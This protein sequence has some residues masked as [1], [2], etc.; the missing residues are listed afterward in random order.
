MNIKRIWTL[1]IGSVVGLFL[2]VACGASATSTLVPTPAP[3]PAPAATPAPGSGLT[4]VATPSPVASSDG[5]GTAPTQAVDNPAPSSGPVPTAVLSPVAAPDSSSEA[6]PAAD[7]GVVPDP[8]FQA[9][10]N[11]SRLSTAVWETDF[12][13]HTVAFDEILSGGPG[14]DGIPPIDDPKFTTP[15]LANEWLG[16]LEPV[17]AFEHNGDTRAY[18]LQ[19][20]MWH[21]VVNDVVG[22][23]PVL[24]TFCPLCNSAV[25]FKRT[26]D[27]V[28]LDFGVS[29]N[30]RNSDLIMWDRQ[31]ET[32][33]QQLL[34]VGIVG[35]LAGRRLTFLPAP[36]VSWSDFRDAHPDGK[37]LS[38]D[39]GLSRRYGQNPYV[40]YDRVDNPPFLFRGDPDGRVQ[41]KER[42][43][44]FTIGSVDVAFPFSVLEDEKVVNYNVNGRDV[45]VFFKPGTRTALGGASIGDAA[46]IGATGVFDAVLDGWKLTFRPDGDAYVDNGTGSTWS[47]LGTATEGPLAGSNLVPITHANHFWFAWGAFKPDTMIYQGAG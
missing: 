31:T 40:G 24:V 15:E 46:E 34:G 22:G 47:I 5:A 16:D 42:V 12:S 19:I 23:E 6:R 4:G 7:P 14:R 29:G 20:L 32:W 45:A 1:G 36:I 13:R 37:V 10:L 41:P 43:A 17:I 27:G 8:D 44:A 25:V 30:L 35:E 38:R 11:S 28:V 33:W 39:T 21:D 9:K 3:T 18:T 26:L 2:F